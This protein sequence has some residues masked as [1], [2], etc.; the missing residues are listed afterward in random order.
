M[1]KLLELRSELNEVTEHK[2][3]VHQLA[4]FPYTSNEQLGIE[5]C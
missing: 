3:H 1:K 5:I 4:I 2:A